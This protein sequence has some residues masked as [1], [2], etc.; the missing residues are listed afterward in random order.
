[1]K[2][3]DLFIQNI[4][5]LLEFDYSHRQTS[6]QRIWQRGVRVWPVIGTPLQRRLSSRAGSECIYLNKQIPTTK[7]L[8]Y[9]HVLVSLQTIYSHHKQVQVLSLDV[10]ACALVPFGPRFDSR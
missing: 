5:I 10:S 7:M 8:I 3:Q 6:H 9:M 1:M 2:A 4:N